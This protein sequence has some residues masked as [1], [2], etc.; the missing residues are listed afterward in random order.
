MD[1]AGLY[2]NPEK[3][4]TAWEITMKNFIKSVAYLGIYF[5]IQLVIQMAFMLYAS[6][7][8]INT[9]AALME[10]SMDNLFLMTIIANIISVIIFALLIKVQK[11]S[12]IKEWHLVSAST[13]IYIYSVI[14]AFLFSFAWA[15]FTYGISFSNA[16][17][18][19][20]S[21]AFYSGILPGLGKVLMAVTLLLV[22]PVIEEVLCRGIILTRLENSMPDWAA[23]LTSSLLFGIIHLM[24][25]GLLL[26]AGATLMGIFFGIIFIKT[27][28][29]YVTIAAHAFA[30]LPDFIIPYLPELNLITRIILAIIFILISIAGIVLLYKKNYVHE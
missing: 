5:I 22:Q 12:I 16:I 24:A 4:K 10:F 21:A 15:F 18:I 30:N 8:G 7:S 6:L 28:S 14:P 19:N 9:E 17:Q 1:K 23:V 2:F 26:T 25:G 27:K 3:Y 11:K 13:G 29:L 20:R